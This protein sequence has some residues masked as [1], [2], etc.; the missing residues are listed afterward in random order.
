MSL[1]DIL[2]SFTGQTQS[3]YLKRAY[4]D[5]QN[6]LNT[7]YN[8]AMKYKNTAYGMYN[9]MVMEGKKAWDLYQGALG[10][11]GMNAANAAKDTIYNNPIFTDTN[12]RAQQ[13]TLAYMNARGGAGG[14]NALAAQQRALQ[15][16]LF[17][18][19]G[20]VEGIGTRGDQGLTNQANI[21]LGQGDL[22]YG[23]GGTR[24]GMA[25]NYGNARAQAAGTL[26]QN[27]INMGAAFMGGSPSPTNYMSG[28]QPIKG[29]AAAWNGWNPQAQQSSNNL[30]NY[31][32]KW[33]G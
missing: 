5:A 4:G 19:L 22:A 9:P 23:Y 10:L 29:D 14:G 28:N 27:L 17:K 3:K 15:D 26:P 21:R 30:S 2:G 33:F 24:A 32:S 7:G 13:D 31:F 16:N 6:Y 20:L 1:K 18:Y 25:T 12:N 8:D 11:K